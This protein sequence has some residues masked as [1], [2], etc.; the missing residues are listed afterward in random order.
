MVCVFLTGCATNRDYEN[1]LETQ[2][3]LSRDATVAEAARIAALTEIA[4]NSDN[5]V[6][7]EAIHALQVKH[8]LSIEP[9]KKNWFGF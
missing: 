8:P 6:K 2:K 1:Y 9:V 5:E 4:K 7:K 3:S